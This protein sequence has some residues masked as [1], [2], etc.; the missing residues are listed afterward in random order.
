MTGL[1]RI[2]GLQARSLSEG[3]L[4]KSLRGFRAIGERLAVRGGGTGVE[5]LICGWQGRL[6]LSAY[7]YDHYRRAVFCP[8]CGAAERHRTLMTVPVRKIQ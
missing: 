6:F 3:Q 8:N 5:C 1:R 7:Y 4:K 2:L